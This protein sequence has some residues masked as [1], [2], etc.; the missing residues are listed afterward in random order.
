MIEQL[1][2]LVPLDRRK[3]VKEIVDRRASLEIV[4]QRFDRHSCADEDRRASEDVRV[5]SYY[6]AHPPY[7]TVMSKVKLQKLLS[8]R[9]GLHDPVFKFEK[10]GSKLA[11][12][13]ISDSFK[14]KSA[15][16][17]V[18]MIWDALDAELGP[19]AVHEVGTLLTYTPEEWN[20]DLP[21]KV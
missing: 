13:V 12:S 14:S 1:S 17:R 7:Y 11:G 20:I 4:K 3:L 16:Q 2:D 5:D 8:Q 19:D 15:R 10:I 18:Q 9:L 21:A 6:F